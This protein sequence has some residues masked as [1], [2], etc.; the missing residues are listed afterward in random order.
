M[1]DIKPANAPDINEQA[2]DYRDDEERKQNKDFKLGNRRTPL[3]NNVLM[4]LGG[5]LEPQTKGLDHINMDM[6]FT[7]LDY[8]GVII[9]KN[10]SFLVTYFNIWGFKKA[11]YLERSNLATHLIANR[12]LNAKS[13]DLFT[14]T[15]STQKQEFQDKTEKKTGFFSFG[16]KKKEEV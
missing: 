4:L 2:R 14:T 9:T 7:F 10:S 13:M 16:T 11:L 1:D 12:S 3:S 5:L 6:S 15:V 8:N